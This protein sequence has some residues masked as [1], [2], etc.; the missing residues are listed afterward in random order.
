M[1]PPEVLAPEETATGQ[2]GIY[3]QARKGRKTPIRYPDMG[4]TLPLLPGNVR[5]SISFP[6]GGSIYLIHRF[7]DMLSQTTIHD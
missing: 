2:K 4:C 5:D 7:R 6:P 1:S 3:P